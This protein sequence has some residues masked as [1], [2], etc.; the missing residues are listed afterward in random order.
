[1]KD[2]GKRNGKTITGLQTPTK[3]YI[4]LAQCGLHCMLILKAI[5]NPRGS[6]GVY[7]SSAYQ[8]PV[9]RNVLT[10]AYTIKVKDQKPNMSDF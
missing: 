6:T 10:H 4:P 2:Y 3:A 9:T 8:L 1:M 5:G 7:G